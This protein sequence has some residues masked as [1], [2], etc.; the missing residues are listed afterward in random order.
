MYF[1]GFFFEVRVRANHSD[2]ARAGLQHR[3]ARHVQPDP[4][5]LAKPRF[6][7]KAFR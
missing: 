1:G 2:D 7:S 6:A 4:S 5:D 3:P